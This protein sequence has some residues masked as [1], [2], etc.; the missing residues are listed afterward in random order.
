MVLLCHAQC[1]HGLDY[2]SI[3]NTPLRMRRTIDRGWAWCWR[4]HLFATAEVR[5]GRSWRS[6]TVSKIT[7]LARSINRGEGD[8]DAGPLARGWNRWLRR[9]GVGR[10]HRPRHQKH[11]F[12]L[13][14][15]TIPTLG[16]NVGEFV[17]GKRVMSNGSTAAWPI[18][19]A[20]S[21]KERGCGLSKHGWLLVRL[22]NGSIRTGRRRAP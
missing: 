13:P 8:L 15:A 22:G 2:V 7:G 3:H 18:K 21:A 1:L 5:S 19:P 16:K 14:P 9:L 12:G 11:T 6:G 17:A 20:A 4:R 10:Y